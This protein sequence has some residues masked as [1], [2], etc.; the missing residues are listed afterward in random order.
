MVIVRAAVV[1]AAVGINK[2]SFMDLE[3]DH[4]FILVEP[5]AKC[6]ELLIELGLE[7]SFSRVHPGQGTTNRCFNFSNSKLELLWVSDAE[8]SNN[9][10][11][12]GLKFP[13]RFKEKEASPFGFIFNRKNTIKNN[14]QDNI[15]LDMPF[16]G[17]SY[18]PDY[19]PVPSAFH[20]GNNSENLVEPLC[21]YVPFMEPLDRVIEKGK[22]KSI[23]HVHLH[24]PVA[25]LSEEL[26]IVSNSDGL[27]IVCG[28]EHLMEITFDQKVCGLSKDLRPGLP[29]ILHW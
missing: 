14:E 22:F 19:F 9:G 12:S 8:E 29:L 20:I 5:E 3:L 1:A 6:A 24:V 13:E 25:S 4:F 16:N 15:D 28:T 11:A 7:E 26:Q 2:G 18:Q 17:W 23:S 27:S 21:I 10:P